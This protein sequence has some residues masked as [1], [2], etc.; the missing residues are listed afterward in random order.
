MKRT[1]GDLFAALRAKKNLTMLDSGLK[2]GLSEPVVWKLE[3]NRPVRWETVHAILSKSFK[4][5]ASSEEYQEIHAAWL[6]Q[7][8]E[9]ADGMAEDANKRKLSTHAAAAVRKFRDL[10]RDLDEDQTKKVLSAARRSA[11]AVRGG[12]DP[13]HAAD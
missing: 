7:R 3:N 2:A 10:V 8:Q 11:A 9:R 13:P 1:V 6:R 5:R 4:I 12:I